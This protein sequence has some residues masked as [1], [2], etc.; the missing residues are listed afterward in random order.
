MRK[1]LLLAFLVLAAT[2]AWQPMAFAEQA[3]TAQPTKIK[4]MRMI[5][6]DVNQVNTFIGN[7]RLTRGTLI[8]KGDRMTIRQDPEGNQYGTLYGKK[9]ELAFF[10]QKRDGGPNLW[11][12]GYAERIEYDSQTEISKLFYRAKLLRLEGKRI[13]DEVNGNFISYESPTEIYTVSNVVKGDPKTKGERIKVILPPKNKASSGATTPQQPA[14][15]APIK[16]NHH[17]SQHTGR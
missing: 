7:V 13:V 15:T 2:S 5:Y 11:V 6:D 3:D 10:R 1:K 8:M 14:R 4:A 9:G 12:E 17:D 16:D